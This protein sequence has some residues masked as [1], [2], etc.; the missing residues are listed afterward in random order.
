[1]SGVNKHLLGRFFPVP[2][3]L[4]EIEDAGPLNQQ[5]VRATEDIMDS[6]PN[7]VPASWSCDLYTTIQT[8]NNLQDHPDFQQLKAHILSEANKLGDAMKL[9]A[10]LKIVSCWLNVCGKSHSQEIHNHSNCI[11]SGVY[12]VQVPEGAPGIIFHSP[13]ADLMLQP[14]KKEANDLNMLTITQNVSAGQMVIFPSYLRHSVP[15]NHVDGQRI[16]VAFNLVM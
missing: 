16:S 2:I 9:A 11:L 3:Q 1:M 15:S 7:R 8:A 12:Y 13:M 14:P 10:P 6:T 4:S 5:L